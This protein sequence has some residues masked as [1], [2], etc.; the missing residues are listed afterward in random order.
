MTLLKRALATGV[1]LFAVSLHG[2]HAFANDTWQGPYGGV[3][4]GVGSFSGR[5]MDW[6]NAIF[7]DPDGDI[8]QRGFAG[9]FGAQAGYNYQL[10]GLVFGLEGDGS[11][12]GFS[13]GRI[14]DNST[15]YVK[16]NMDWL[17]T[18]R[19]RMGVANDV[20]MAYVTGGLALAGVGHCANDD[21][22]CSADNTNDV[23]WSG[24]RPGLVAGAGVEARLS[25]RWSFKS[26]YLY[27]VTADKNIVFDTSENQDIDFGF[28][29]HV[30]R[31][32][33]NYKL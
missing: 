3:S 10:G 18:V 8:D 32:G 11:W 16:A 30:F 26:E 31:V 4:G 23:A 22:P 17:A 24:T 20:A 6:G 19:G 25:E 33:L 27:L 9:V 1:A 29:A 28:D 21:V 14:F 5:A 15:R 13:E 7:R 12:T 2:G